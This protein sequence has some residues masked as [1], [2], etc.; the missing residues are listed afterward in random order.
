MIE[1]VAG[2][3]LAVSLAYLALDRFR[4]RDDVERYAQNKKTLLANEGDA[5]T[6]EVVNDLRWLCREDCNGHTPRGSLAH[7][8]HYVFRSK[9][10]E[11]LIALSALWAAFTLAAGVAFNLGTWDFLLVLNRPPIAN[12]MFAGC[13]FALG[14]PAFA[15]LCGRKCVTWGKSFADHCESEIAKIHKRSAQQATVPSIS[16]MDAHSEYLRRARER[17]ERAKRDS[18]PDR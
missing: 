16:S 9:A 8:Y 12:S 3:G 6:L 13:L 18:P 7:F 5:D 14:F 15:V 11:V 10:D 1:P 4:Y 17:L 2:A